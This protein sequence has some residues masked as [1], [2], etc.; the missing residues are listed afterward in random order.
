MLPWTW[1]IA[2]RRFQQ[3]VLIRFGHSQAVSLGTAVRLGT[4]AVVMIGGYLLATLPGGAGRVSG[5]VVASAALAASTAAEAIYAGLRVRPVLRR[6]VRP[7]APVD[8]PLTVSAF[9]HFYAPLAMTSLLSLVVQPVGSAAVSRMPQALESLAV[10]PVLS[11]FIFVLRSAGMA[12]NEVVIALLD[13]PRSTR[14]LRRFAFLLAA[15]TTAVLLITAATPLAPFWFQRVSGLKP[16]LA[17][18]AHRGLWLALPWPALNVLYSWYQGAIVHSRRTRA[19]TEA[20]FIYLLTSSGILWAGVAWGQAPG[21]YVAV[22][23]FVG[24]VVAQTFWL[25]HRSRR[26]VRAVEKRDESAATIRAADI[27][28]P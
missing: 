8:E 12:Y 7:A 3:G 26:A 28:A 17:D 4:D 27:A 15:V 16:H 10:W 14:T 19:I 6:Q 9:L 5:I 23:A 13:E 24:G 1:T 20:V 25:W 11:G 22:V 2:Y 21:L 18:L